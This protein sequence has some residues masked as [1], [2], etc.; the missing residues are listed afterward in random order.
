[1]PC[2][3]WPPSGR[4]SRAGGKSRLAKQKQKQKRERERESRNNSNYKN[5]TRKTIGL[6]EPT[7]NQCQRTEA[8]HPEDDVQQVFRVIGH[9][10]EMDP[11]LVAAAC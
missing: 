8:V 2:A 9:T 4:Q 1:V 5:Q 6:R 10:K 3:H 11:A 7:H